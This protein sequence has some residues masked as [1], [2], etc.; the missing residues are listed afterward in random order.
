MLTFVTSCAGGDDGVNFE[1]VHLVGLTLQN[2]ITL[3]VGTLAMSQVSSGMQHAV[4][5]SMCIACTA[6]RTGG[7]E[8]PPTQDGA[9]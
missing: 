8:S 1:H 9:A 7:G 6:K 2:I 3:L 5:C 4:V